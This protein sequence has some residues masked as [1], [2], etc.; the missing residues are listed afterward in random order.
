MDADAG[1]AGDRPPVNLVGE[2]VALGPLSRALLP[3]YQAWM[4]DVATQGWAGFPARPEPFTDERMAQ[5]YERA[6]TDQERLWFT[7][8]ETGA[9]R[10]VGFCVLRDIDHRHRTAEFGLTIGDRSDRGKGYG[11]EA[12][13]LLLDLA[14]TG[15]GLHNVQ[16]Q[17][18]EFNRAGLRAYQK[19]GFKE[20]G[21]R[22]R[23]YFMGRRFWDVVYMDCLAEEFS[24]PVLGAVLASGTTLFG[25]VA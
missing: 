25:N 7:V 10:A 2:R 23:A 18:Y 13:T 24:S 16:L 19:A 20:I 11:T 21:R 4:N 9:W 17:V 5:W 8:Y 12:V 1:D 15:L 14:F 3:R 22:R 6:A